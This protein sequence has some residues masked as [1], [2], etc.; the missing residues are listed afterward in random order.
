MPSIKKRINLTVPDDLYEKLQQYKERY[1]IE[2][3]A[4]ACIQLI[5]QQLRSLEQSE[6]MMDFIRHGSMEQLMQ[7]TQEGFAAIKEVPPEKP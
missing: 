6:A 5:T 1:G 2:N 7:L 4:S 3:D